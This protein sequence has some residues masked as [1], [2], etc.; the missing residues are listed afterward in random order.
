MPKLLL[1][2]LLL[3]CSTLTQ[4]QRYLQEV[5]P[6]VDVQTNLNYGN[7]PLWN[8]SPQALDLDVFRPAGDNQNNR[9][10]IIFF[11]GGSF[12]GGQRNDAVMLG[13]CNTFAKRGY[14]T[15]TASY[16]LGVNNAN[17]A[18]L[19]REFV[20]AALRATHDA[21]AAVRFFK[22]S[23]AEQG[24]PYGI[25]TNKI[26]VGGY[27][28]GAIAAIHL[29]YFT[30]TLQSSTL[31][32]QEIMGL[33]VGL[34]GNSGNPGY[35]S[36][37]AG[38]LNI[39]GAVLD[40]NLIKTGAVTGIHFHGTADEVVPYGRGMI[41]AVGFPV[42]LVDGSSLLHQ[43]LQNR[44]TYSELLSYT[45]AMHDFVSTPS[46]SADIVNN[47]ARFFFN[48]QNNSVSLAEKPA[49]TVNIY[50]NP[51]SDWLRI[52]NN[53]GLEMEVELKNMHGQTLLQS[54]LADGEA[55]PLTELTAGFY[56]LQI[57][58][59]NNTQ[60]HKIVIRK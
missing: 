17:L 35:T 9:P 2:S 41:R 20:K 46:I 12:I 32:N 43:R 7:A 22:R 50:P 18:A 31:V 23:V 44:G 28:A 58:Q 10:L 54:L 1:L 33:G 39:A 34:E 40:T 36:T 8:N 51:S 27:S 59:N 3:L 26:Y 13:L 11:H 5:F 24:N 45:G 48:L 37:A 16:R 60:L 57:T 14:V 55:L 29:A 21:K 56:L 6:V 42:I 52:E 15:A 25:D 47:A 49:L 19:D 38:V 53:Q 4:A 30:D